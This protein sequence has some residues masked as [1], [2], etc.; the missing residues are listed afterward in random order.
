MVSIFS[1]KKILLIFLLLLGAITVYSNRSSTIELSGVEIARYHKAGKEYILAK[2]LL[3]LGFEAVWEGN[4]LFLDCTTPKSQLTEKYNSPT[5]TPSM[6]LMIKLNGINIDY[7]MVHGEIALSID[8][9]CSP[10][11]D[12]FDDISHPEEY[13]TAFQHLGYSAYYFRRNSSDSISVLPLEKSVVCNM[14]ETSFAKLCKNVTNTE[15]EKYLDL[16]NVLQKMNAVYK[17]QDNILDIYEDHFQRLSISVP[18][19]ATNYTSLRYPVLAAEIMTA[20]MQKISAYI[21]KG[22]LKVNTAEFCEAYGYHTR[23]E[24]SENSCKMIIIEK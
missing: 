22:R 4:T 8:D 20:D 7:K 3:L 1:R 21:V 15:M 10:K 14:G 16:E 19:Q 23:E 24:N 18:D 17:F 5:I 9:L 12:S 13:Y 2:D 11:A 6:D